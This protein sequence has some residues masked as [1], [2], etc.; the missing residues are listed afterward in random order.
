MRDDRFNA[1]RKD[2]GYP[3]AGFD[4]NVAE[5]VAKL[6]APGASCP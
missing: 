4:A 5:S 1:L 6:V 3:V 2:D